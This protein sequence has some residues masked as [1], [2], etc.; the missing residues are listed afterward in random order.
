MTNFVTKVAIMLDATARTKSSS[1]VRLS[2][3]ALSQ[4]GERL[5]AFLSLPRAT[6]DMIGV[7]SEKASVEVRR[8]IRGYVEEL[9]TVVQERHEAA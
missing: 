7:A 6:I 3:A 8:G 4:E 1:L 9:K 5:F 2:D